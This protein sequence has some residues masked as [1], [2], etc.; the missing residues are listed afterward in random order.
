MA[1]DLIGDW[2]VMK[3]S[4]SDIEINGH[5]VHEQVEPL[6]EDTLLDE[7]GIGFPISQAGSWLG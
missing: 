1:T 5:D 2:S 3:L 7:S 6:N 4:C